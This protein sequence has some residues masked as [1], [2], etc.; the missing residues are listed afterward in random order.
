MFEP[1][2]PSALYRVLR[3]GV[4]GLLR[5]FFRRIAVE[6]RRHLP[7]GRGGLLVA[8]HPNGLIDPALILSQFP[9]RIVFGA[10]DGL[11]RWPVLGPMMRALGTVPIYRPQ[12]TPAGDTGADPAA[13][14]AAR[15]AANATSLDALAA[16]IASG[17]YAAL[18][19]EGV[20]HDLPH[21][22][23]VRAGAARLYARALALTP[24]G[25]PAPALVPVGLHYDEKA[26]FR[27]SVLVAF[28]API[29]VPEAVL[30]G[31]VSADAAEARAAVDALTAQIERALVRAVHATED[32]EIHRTMHRAAALVRAEAARRDG[33]R[34]GEATTAE[35]TLGFAQMWH[36]YAARRA[37]H[38]AEVEAL[39]E[40]V[41]AYARRLDALGLADADLDRPPRL[42][43]PL[44]WALLMLQA[45][46]VFV[47]LPPLLVA[48]FVINAPPHFLL[49]GL[50][51]RLAR[52]QKDA[53]TVKL[54][55]GLVLYPL[56]WLVAGGLAVW[57]RAGL[58]RS[59]P[60]LP[61]APLR[62]F[63]AVVVLGAVG[64]VV[65]LRYSELAGST[66]RALAVRLT[67]ARRRT[68]V[69]Q[70]RARRAVLHDRLVALAE[71]LDLPDTVTDPV[72]A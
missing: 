42:A 7:H 37:T 59:F 40:T 49:K 31:L 44:L 18:F 45:V 8:W 41:D 67:R 70:L 54:M 58:H 43:D 28:H 47:L 4:G 10:R 11:L 1:P 15:R 29:A 19:P 52:L 27:S 65:A 20:S 16:E 14:E 34:V 72:G 62:T 66:V 21:V 60:A 9:G 13:A 25:S 69:A 3:A 46:G 24:S 22:A 63:L 33:R 39:R 30:A 6:G 12:D 64:A 50:A 26:V 2:V 35:R 61:V 23:E 68:A 38:P 71:G 53:A 57:A 48:G 5:L 51:R 17:S 32:W 55:A 56:A 36:G